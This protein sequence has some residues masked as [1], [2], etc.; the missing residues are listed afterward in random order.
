MDTTSHRQADRPLVSIIIVVWNAQKVVLETLDSLQQFLG[1]TSAEIIAV[2]N[3]STD[4]TPDV[5][6]RDYPHVKLIR[7]GGNFGFAR[8]NNIGIQH[9]TGKY[10]AF[11]NSDVIFIENSFA[12]MLQYMD[13]HPD[14]GMLGPK[15][16]D[17]ARLVAR[18][19]M[20]FPTVWNTLSRALALDTLFKG[21]RFFEG[22]LML[23][24]DHNE[25]TDVDVLAGWFWLVRRSA[26]E[27]VGMLDESFFMYG[28]DVDW[29]YRFRQAGERVVFFAETKAVHIGGASS[30]VA[31][32]RFSVEKQ[33]ATWQVFKKH[34]GPAKRFGLLLT[35]VLHNATRAV[36]YGLL[37]LV[38]PA[39]RAESLLKCRRSIAC[40][41]WLLRAGF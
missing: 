11:V 14:I 17:P 13:T 31:P 37:Y 27:K 15:M 28:E 10:L 34:F 32:V 16:L 12:P 30:S 36:S 6:A 35:E 40:L 1:V 8:A 19:T 24:F 38:K 26:L 3:A 33:R 5:I 29:C 41:G 20:R 39:D 23:D 22:H 9:S 7:N 25:T 21:V 4:G 18:S 2:D